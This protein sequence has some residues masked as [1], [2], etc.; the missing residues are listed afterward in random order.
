MTADASSARKRV[1]SHLE[2]ILSQMEQLKAEKEGQE[3]EVE[4]QRMMFNEEKKKYASG[5]LRA[6]P[7]SARGHSLTLTRNLPSPELC[8]CRRTVLG[9]TEA[10][11]DL[12]RACQACSS[13]PLLPA[14]WTRP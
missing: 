11:R 8:T 7:D 10:L 3:Q 6:H 14:P 13:R 2:E 1:S 9:V 12:T 4:R 5:A